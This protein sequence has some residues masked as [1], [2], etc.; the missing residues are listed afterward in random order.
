[1]VMMRHASTH[2]RLLARKEDIHPSVLRFGERLL[3]AGYRENRSRTWGAA[4]AAMATLDRCLNLEAHECSPTSA[5]ALQ[6]KI[7][8]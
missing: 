7:N 8:D 4:T 3:D 5:S 1:M 6:V 2:R